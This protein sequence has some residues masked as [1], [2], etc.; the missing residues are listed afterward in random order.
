MKKFLVFLLLI[1]ASLLMTASIDPPQRVDYDVGVEYVLPVPTTVS[2][3]FAV[4]YDCIWNEW[5]GGTMPGDICLMTGLISYQIN[6]FTE[7]AQ[8][9]EFKMINLQ[10]KSATGYNQ[11][12]FHDP[13]DLLWP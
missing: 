11:F 10:C 2:V 8:K 1:S 12:S 9:H 7:P 6:G 5:S 13:G 3:V 4:D